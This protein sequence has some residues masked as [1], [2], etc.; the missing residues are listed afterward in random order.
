MRLDPALALIYEHAQSFQGT[1]DEKTLY[2]ITEFGT[3][4][5]YESLY[6]MN[7]IIGIGN[8]ICPMYHQSGTPIDLSRFRDRPAVYQVTSPAFTQTLSCVFSGLKR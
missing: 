8:I 1:S 2:H 7:E 3:D 5:K 6:T 4:V